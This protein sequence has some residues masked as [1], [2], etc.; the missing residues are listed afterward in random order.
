MRL[1]TARQDYKGTKA[2]YLVTRRVYEAAIDEY[3]QAL[4]D[5]IDDESADYKQED[6]LSA[7]KSLKR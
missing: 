7:E 3:C 6:F 2:C 4:K 1:Q 5:T